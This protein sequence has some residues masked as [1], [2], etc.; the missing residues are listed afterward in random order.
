MII[1]GFAGVLGNNLIQFDV[2]WTGSWTFLPFCLSQD[3]N[4]GKYKHTDQQFLY[5][6]TTLREDLLGNT[7][8]SVLLLQ[9]C[10]IIDHLSLNIALSGMFNFYWFTWRSNFQKI[11]ICQ[12]NLWSLKLR[13]Y[14][15]WHQHPHWE[16]FILYI[17]VLWWKLC[18]SMFSTYTNSINLKGKVKNQQP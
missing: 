16:V 11:A 15:L 13:C 5:C 3:M 12:I 9:V 4:I 17:P 14:W 18:K 7:R 10:S 2:M 1:S 6:I 8:R